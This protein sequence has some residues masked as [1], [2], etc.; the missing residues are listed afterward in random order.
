MESVWKISRAKYSDLFVP[1][2]TK[3]AYA[4]DSVMATEEW[5]REHFNEIMMM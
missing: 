3:M 4:N 1:R 5:A 2:V